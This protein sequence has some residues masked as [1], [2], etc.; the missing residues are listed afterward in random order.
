MN[1]FIK[2]IF[3]TLIIQLGV[4]YNSSADEKAVK[5]CFERVNRATFAF[6]M[7]IDKA[8][9]KPVSKGY[10]MLPS[11]IR[12]GT[13][14]ALNNL[15]NLVTVPNNILQGD[16]SAAMNNTGRFIINSTIGILGIF[17]PAQSLGLN[18]LDKEDYGQSFGKMGIGEGCYLV[19]P[20]LGPSSARDAF[21]TVLTVYGGDPWY[22]V[23]VKNDTNYVKE[24]DYYYSKGTE[25]IDFRAKNLESFDSIEK[26]SIDFYATVRSLYI[27]DRQRKINNSNV[28]T[29]SLD[30]SDW[31]NLENK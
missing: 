5:D 19:L 20:I 3:F 27:Q 30:D 28:I 7:A 31:E 14:N 1:R 26:N 18:K 11:P 13:S 15:S 25:G 16:L 17:D 22:N 24:S 8:L 12:S 4:V 2:I 10:R 9:F 21:G 6:N 23:T 29:E